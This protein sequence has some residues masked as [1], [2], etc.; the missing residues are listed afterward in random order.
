MTQYSSA[1]SRWLAP[2]RGASRRQ[3]VGLTDC[4]FTA[5]EPSVIATG[6]EPI[7]SK[8]RCWSS[9]TLRSADF[10]IDT[11]TRARSQASISLSLRYRRPLISISGGRPS[12]SSS[13]QRSTERLDD[14]PALGLLQAG[15]EGFV[16]V[17]CHQRPADKLFRTER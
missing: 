5:P 7:R 13:P 16:G 15:E 17:V 4:K 1:R 10:G 6:A 9:S 14:A 11:T 8:Q 3:T 2:P 12:L